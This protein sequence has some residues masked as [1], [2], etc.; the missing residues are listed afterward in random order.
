[1]LSSASKRT[2]IAEVTDDFLH[3]HDRDDLPVFLELLAQALDTRIDRD[4]ASLV[5]C[6]DRKRR[7]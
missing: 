5:R 1:M 2:A 4:A 6:L 7:S 3:H